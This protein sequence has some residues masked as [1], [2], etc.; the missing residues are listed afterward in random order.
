MRSSPLDESDVMII[1]SQ[2]LW[3]RFLSFFSCIQ[4]RVSEN[5]CEL[6]N[7]LS[8]GSSFSIRSQKPAALSCSPPLPCRPLAMTTVEWRG[9]FKVTGFGQRTL[10]CGWIS[11]NLSSCLPVDPWRNIP[12]IWFGICCFLS[13]FTDTA[14]WE[15]GWDG[16]LCMLVIQSGY[17]R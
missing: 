11:L 7:T 10:M 3:E 4:N 2:V 17:S 15:H 6:N 13:I 5:Q 12:G 9:Y 14:L 8:C 16:R 1:V